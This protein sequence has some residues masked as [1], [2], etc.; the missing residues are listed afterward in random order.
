MFFAGF[1]IA[2]ARNWLL[3]FALSSIVPIIT[4]VG[5]VLNR[6]ESKC[7]TQQLANTAEGGSLAEEVLSSTRNVIAFGIK[8]RLLEIY[9]R[10]NAMTEK[11]G[12]RSILIRAP[13]LAVMFF[14]IYG[15]Y[16]LAFQF[17]TTL[18][19]EGKTSSGQIVSCVF[20]IMIGAFSLAQLA[21]NM[22]A[23]ASGQGAASKIFDTIDRTPPIDSFSEEGQK[24]DV[25]GEIELKDITFY[26]PS[27]PS[28]KILD[29]VGL[30]LP[31]GSKTALVGPSGG[32]KS[33]CIGL[34]ERWYDPINGSVKFDGV[35]IKDIN[36]RWLRQHIGLVQQEPV[37]FAGTV[38]QNVAHGLIGDALDQSPDKIRSLVVE[39]CKKANAHD[40][41]LNLP[42]GYD[43]DLGERGAGLSGGQKQRIAI[44]RA[45]VSSPPI[46]LLDEATSALD[47]T[48]ERIVQDALNKASRGRT[49]LSIAHRLST[50]KDCDNIVVLVQGKIVESGTHNELLERKGAY[51]KLVSAQALREEVQ[52][53]DHTEEDNDEDARAEKAAFK[54]ADTER[55]MMR[56][57]TAVSVASDAPLQGGNKTKKHSAVSLFWRIG[58]LNR[59]MVGMYA[60]GLIGCVLT[61]AV[62][63]VF[64]ILFVRAAFINMLWSVMEADL[65][66][67]TTSGQ[68]PASVQLA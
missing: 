26:Y 35:D 6:F 45:I 27:R 58:R 62:Y 56:R 10:T 33:S 25:K 30:R 41:I 54:E 40:F 4:V 24:L 29:N 13:A 38:A 44:A 9:E 39:A 3:A 66:T 52:T 2:F 48:A 15:A 65:P 59:E 61:G 17:G 19:L 55:K 21:P 42:N 60:I 7:K 67:L 14:C 49:T 63:P 46:L 11:F 37:L 68:D 64:G 5:F 18:I 43:S 57:P 53:N 36:L 20:S 1:A 28:L 12:T 22:V 50:V 47:T 23:I 32:G 16:G 51:A 31:I 34:L 8:N